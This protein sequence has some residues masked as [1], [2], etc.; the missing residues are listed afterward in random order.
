MDPVQ[1]FSRTIHGSDSSRHSPRNQFVA[2][3]LREQGMA[4]LLSDLL[5]VSEE[6]INRRTRELR[7]NIDLLAERLAGA[8]DWI[9]RQSGVDG[10]KLGCFGASTGAAAALMA[11]G[12]YDRPVKAIVSRGGRPDL[13]R[14]DLAA[15][16]V[17]TLL[18]VGGQNTAVID[19]NKTALHQLGGE[20]QLEIVPNATHL[21][22]EPGALE[23]VAELAANWFRQHFA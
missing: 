13:S 15:V 23:Q 14:T 10:L 12:R 4:T 18:I 6:R 3:Y 5:T 11:A 22:Q 7:F 19:M 21:F 16:H 20:K 1:G 2:E 17:P 8:A 9:Y